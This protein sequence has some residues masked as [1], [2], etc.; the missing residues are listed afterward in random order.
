[1]K[2][3]ANLI[4]VLFVMMIAACRETADSSPALPLVTVSSG[5][6][7]ASVNVEIAATFNQRQQ[8][9]MLR[10]S[11][12]E[13]RGMLFLFRGDVPY[14]FWMKNTYIPLDIAY[15]SA[16]GTVLEIV[17]GKPLDETILTPH[18]RYRYVLEVNDGWF[19]RHNLGP[20]AHVTLPGKLPDADP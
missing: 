9:L 3:R 10:Q 20:G 5:E 12:E 16:D 2:L 18:Q 17:H 7:T 14:G 15:I 11:L 4:Y 13:D 19:E 1:M 8:G 6:A